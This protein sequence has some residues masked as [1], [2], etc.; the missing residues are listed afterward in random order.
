MYLWHCTGC[1]YAGHNHSGVHQI[2]LS[3]NDGVAEYADV[4]CE[5]MT[6]GG[7]WTVRKIIYL[8]LFL[9][10]TFIDSFKC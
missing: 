7:G 1:V 9:I 5:M 2:K 8:V 6:D 3:T 4:Y 10:S